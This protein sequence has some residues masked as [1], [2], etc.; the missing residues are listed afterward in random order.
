[1]GQ[2]FGPLIPLAVA[3][4]VSTLPACVTILVL[5]SDNR[6]RSA[7]PYLV[8]FVVGTLLLVT[9]GTLSAS[10]LPP[11]RPRQPNTLVG[12]IEIL[13]GVA[14]VALGVLTGVDARRGRAA[15]NPRGG[16]GRRVGAGGPSAWASR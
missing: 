10:L 9:V 11:P 6:D 1:M 2:D 8:G 5:L 16:G 14:L 15:R 4:A 3:A 7:L 13:I 12:V